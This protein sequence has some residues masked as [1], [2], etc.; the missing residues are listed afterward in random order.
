MTRRIASAATVAG[1]HGTAVLRSA[2][3]LETLGKDTARRVR[4][5]V[6]PNYVRYA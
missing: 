5:T 6:A 4:R 3:L 1:C 2:V